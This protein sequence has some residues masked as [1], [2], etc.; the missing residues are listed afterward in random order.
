MSSVKQ[1]PVSGKPH[2]KILLNRIESAAGIPDPAH[3]CRVI[4][5]MI[6]EYKKAVGHE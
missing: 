1:D 4:L 6:K 3:A 5:A 2:L